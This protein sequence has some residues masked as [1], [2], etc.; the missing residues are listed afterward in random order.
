MTEIVPNIYQLQLPMPNNPLLHANSYLVRGDN[1][2]LLIDTGWDTEQTLSSLKKQLAEVGTN[3][4][5]IS[6]IVVTHTH[7]DHYALVPRL[8]ELC[9]A[10]VAMHSLEGDLL[11]QPSYTDVDKFIQQEIQWAYINGVSADVGLQLLSEMQ[12][13]HPEMMES[14]APVLPDTTLHGGETI[15]VGSFTFRVLWTPGHSPGHICLYE[16]NQEILISGDHILP[17]AVPDVGV[18]LEPGSSPNPLGDYLNSLNEMKQLNV[19]LILPGHGEPFPGFQQRI[20]EL[21]EF[22]RRRSSEILEAAKV[23]AKTAYQ[24][25]GEITWMVN[26]KPVSQQDLGAWERSLTLV[27][28]LAHLEAL[29]SGGKVGK[30]LKDNLVYYHAT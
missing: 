26:M 22:H 28:T 16:P 11:Q 17:A 9:Q 3:L 6:K 10:E 1:E 14:V 8:R 23:E 2:C 27:K 20:E 21:I 18:I 7:P 25:A 29:R 19:S 4:E 5:D 15:S 24:I 30:F 13:T 12:T